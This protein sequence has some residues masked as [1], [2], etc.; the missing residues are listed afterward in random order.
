MSNNQS[1]EE[2]YEEYKTLVFNLSLHYLQQ[3]EEA[4]DISQEVFVKVHQHYH[5]Y[6]ANTA[7]LKTW[8][9]RITVNQCLDFIKSKKSKKRFGFLTSLFNADTNEPISEAIQL[10]HPGIEAEDKEEL[11]TLLQIINAL[12]E[13]QKTAII[14]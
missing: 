1:F 9:Y 4:E 10:N 12:P 8:I 3:K 14:L 7:S 11:N 13:N 6:D 5:T 2:I